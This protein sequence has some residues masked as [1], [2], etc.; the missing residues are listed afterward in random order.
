MEIVKNGDRNNMGTVFITGSVNETETVIGMGMEI[1]TVT[2]RHWNSMGTK[3]ERLGTVRNGYGQER[4]RSGTGTVRNVN[5]Q[6]RER[7][8]T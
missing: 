5:G 6:E 7:S 2:G 4:E 1:I 8:G 3:R